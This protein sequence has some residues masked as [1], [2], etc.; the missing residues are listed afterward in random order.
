MA[1]ERRQLR[2]FSFWPLNPY[3]MSNPVHGPFRLGDGNAVWKAPTVAWVAYSCGILTFGEPS[4]TAF[5]LLVARICD[6]VI[7]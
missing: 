6:G 4:P 3:G 7:W 5:L 1:V 2:S